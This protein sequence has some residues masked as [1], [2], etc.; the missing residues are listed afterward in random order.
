LANARPIAVPEVTV[1]QPY[2]RKTLKNNANTAF[3]ADESNLKYF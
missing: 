1:N 2:A 3:C